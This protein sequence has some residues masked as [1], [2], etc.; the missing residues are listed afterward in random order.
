MHDGGLRSLFRKYL[1]D[2]DWASIET[3]GTIPGVPDSNFCFPGGL[4]GWVENKQIW[5]WTVILRP[6]QVGWIM[7]RSRRGGRVFLAVRRK[8]DE[9]HI[10]RGS[11]VEELARRNFSLKKFKTRGSWL[12]GPSAWNWDEVRAVFTEAPI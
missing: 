2:G 3:G 6:A 10:V 9:L 4:E 12:G 5:G 11:D 1:P 8:E 7:R